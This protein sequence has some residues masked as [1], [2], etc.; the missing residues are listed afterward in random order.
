MI[1]NSSGIFDNFSSKFLFK[2]GGRHLATFARI[3]VVK[4][5]STRHGDQNGRGLERCLRE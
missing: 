2:S 5:I 4:Y 1:I 3:L